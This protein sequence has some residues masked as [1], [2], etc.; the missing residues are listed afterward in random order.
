[1]WHYRRIPSTSENTSNPFNNY[2]T[3]LVLTFS[4]SPSQATINKSNDESY[5][6]FG[7]ITERENRT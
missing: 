1:M 7:F 6:G 2:S 4:F 3:I 5:V